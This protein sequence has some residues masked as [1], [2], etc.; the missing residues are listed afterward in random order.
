MKIGQA[1]FVTH[2]QIFLIEIPWAIKMTR[3]LEKEI[4]EK[5]KTF[6]YK[7]KIYSCI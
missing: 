7:K 2:R 3:N 1:K 4:L 6:C 5:V